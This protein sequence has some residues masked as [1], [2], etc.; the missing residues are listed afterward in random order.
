[1]KDMVSFLSLQMPTGILV[2][3]TPSCLSYI[4]VWWSVGW[5]LGER[6]LLGTENGLFS[7]ASCAACGARGLHRLSDREQYPPLSCDLQ[8]W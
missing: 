1:M 2:I 6:F 4:S 5:N 7:L 3:H 8:A